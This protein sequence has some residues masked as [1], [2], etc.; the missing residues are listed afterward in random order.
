MNKDLLEGKWHEFKGK[1]KEK[2][3]KL[4]DDDLAKI[5]GKKEELIGHLQTRYGYAKDRAEK[6]LHEFESS[7]G[8][9][10]SKTGEHHH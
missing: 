6:E 2:W 5:N 4:T 7:C 8:C 3:G 1:I 9:D 10:K